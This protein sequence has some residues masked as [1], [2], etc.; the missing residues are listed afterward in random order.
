MQVRALSQ[1][2]AFLVLVVAPALAGA[3]AIEPAVGLTSIISKTEQLDEL[4][5]V[6]KK[7]YRIRMD[8]VDVEDKFFAL[9]NDLNRNDEFDIHCRIEAP[10]GTLLK[11]R[12][13][14]LALI[15]SSPQLRELIREREALEKKFR[16]ARKWASRQPRP[17]FVW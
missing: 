9:Y 5:I 3:Q 13:C 16:E 12:I 10:T 11:V 8:A 17:S 1:G 6:G 7:I 15:N 14:R 2:V 4:Q